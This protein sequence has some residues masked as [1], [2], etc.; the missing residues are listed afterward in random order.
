M[1]SD[2]NNGLDENIK[3]CNSLLEMLQLQ[4]QA[5]GDQAVYTFLKDGEV[6][7]GSLTFIELEQKA[8][9]IG[10]YLQAQSTPGDRVLLL[11]SPGLEYISAFLG[12]LY[13]G[14]IAIPAYPP[15]NK[16]HL[17]R[18]QAIVADAQST[19]AMTSTDLIKTTERMFKNAPGLEMLRWV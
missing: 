8:R 19:I 15:R 10:A 17:P 9:A 18:F 5:K 2:S 13:A 7:S 4:M 1:K 3:N 14:V 12:C 11:Y 6:P 16:R